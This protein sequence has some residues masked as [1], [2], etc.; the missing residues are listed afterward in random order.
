MRSIYSERVFVLFSFFL[1][2]VG[3]F[4]RFS[5][6]FIVLAYC[7]RETQFITLF[8]TFRFSTALKTGS[9]NKTT[10]TMGSLNSFP[11]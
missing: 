7:N 3:L 9:I 1:A 5:E 8:E 11:F 6:S 10:V 2:R 4:K